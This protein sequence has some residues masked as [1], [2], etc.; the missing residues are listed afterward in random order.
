MRPRDGERNL[1]DERAAGLVVPQR[2]EQDRLL[3]DAPVAEDERAA[4][5]ANDE[6]LTRV[7]A[8]ER[9][10]RA[11]DVRRVCL[12][13]ERVAAH[14]QEVARVAARPRFGKRRA[15]VHEERRREI[16]SPNPE[17]NV[18]VDMP[19]DVDPEPAV[20]EAE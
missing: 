12:M 1:P 20:V 5:V 6:R 11:F 8:A 4:R 9:E 15:V 13:E 7:D 18:A 14:R 16:A 19:R 2:V 3:E 17:L 10:D